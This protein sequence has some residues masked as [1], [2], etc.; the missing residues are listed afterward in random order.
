[1]DTL[2][3]CECSGWLVG[4]GYRVPDDPV[5]FAHG[6]EKAIVAC[7]HLVCVVCKQPVRIERDPLLKGQE[8]RTYECGCTTFPVG[9]QRAAADDDDLDPAIPWRC[10]GHPVATLPFDLDGVR[11]ASNTDFGELMRRTLGGWIPEAARPVERECPVGWA[12]KLYVRLL[13]TGLEDAVS[14]AVAR[15]GTDPDPRVRAAALWFLAL[16]PEAAGAERVE[17]VV[18]GDRSLFAG[19]PNP[20]GPTGSMLEDWL[21]WALGRRLRAR[22]ADGKVRA[23]RALRLARAEVLRPGRGAALFPSLVEA[24]QDWLEKKAEE[25]VRANPDS[26]APLLTHLYEGRVGRVALRLSRLPGANRAGLRRFVE[27]YTDEE[28]RDQILAGIGDGDSKGP[29]DRGA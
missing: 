3:F 9:S 21:L 12:I 14:R 20:I 11:I 10:V 22:S 25:I 17:D 19:L 23:R 13:D 2:H 8:F 5:E 16:F 7:T 4:P 26:W 28:E 6:E 27:R 29:V 1:M 24:D 18:T 15:L